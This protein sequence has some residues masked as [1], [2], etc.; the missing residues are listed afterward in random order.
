[1]V[2]ILI[3]AERQAMVASRW[4]DSE[5]FDVRIHET[6]VVQLFDRTIGRSV[7]IEHP[8]NDLRHDSHSADATD[9]R[10]LWSNNN[11]AWPSEISGSTPKG[12]SEKRL[13]CWGCPR[14]GYSYWPRSGLAT[15]PGHCATFPQ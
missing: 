5:A 11:D 4:I 15:A 13:H 1:L 12:L 6:D 2:S 14:W 7:I 10:P 9:G 8:G 3:A